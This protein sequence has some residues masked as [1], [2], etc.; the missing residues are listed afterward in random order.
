MYYNNRYKTF[1]WFLRLLIWPLI[2]LY[3]AR[4]GYPSEREV[5]SGAPWFVAGIISLALPL[6]VLNKNVMVSTINVWTICISLYLIIG[7][8]CFFSEKITNVPIS[9][10]N[11]GRW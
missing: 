1:K 9:W 4:S 11:N 10:Q 7:I 8:I 2:I 5:I 6:I 3:N